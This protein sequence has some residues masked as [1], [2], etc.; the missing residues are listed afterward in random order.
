VWA[1]AAGGDVGLP[2]LGI[3]YQPVA[4]VAVTLPSCANVSTTTAA[5]GTFMLSVPMGT[6]G[7]FRFAGTGYMTTLWN[8]VKFLY[9][10]L[11]CG[12]P[13]FV[14]PL[15]TPA[16]VTMLCGSA[17]ATTAYV[18]ATFLGEGG[19]ACADVSGVVVS[20]AEVPGAKITYVDI[21]G[22]AAPASGATSTKGLSC[23]T[24][25]PTSGLVNIVATKPGC[26][27]GPRYSNPVPLEA[28][29]ITL[30]PMYIQ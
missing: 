16:D 22:N 26:L 20:V 5:D 7:H 8:D 18:L 24:G 17:N 3:S 27:A 12:G 9:D 10:G 6:A 28:G 4:G 13:G 21:N 14:V 19:G 30:V 23:I 25:L 1:V 11:S 29:A 2:G 15:P